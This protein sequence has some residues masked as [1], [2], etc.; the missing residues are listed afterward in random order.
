MSDMCYND[1]EF[2]RCGGVEEPQTAKGI[3]KINYKEDFEVVVELMAGDE[4]YKIGE[5]D[6]F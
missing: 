3:V 2:S 4:P 1:R 5:V 6:D